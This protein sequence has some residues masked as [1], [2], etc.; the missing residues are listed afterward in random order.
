MDHFITH[1]G[2]VVIGILECFVVGWI[3]KA[4]KLREHINRASSKMVL[5]GF[6]DVCIK[7]IIPLVLLMLL[8][9]DLR[10]ELSAPYEG[11]SWV[12]ILIIGRDWLIIALI[13]SLFVAMRPWK[14][15][16]EEAP[17]A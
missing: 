10:V 11:Y 15:E 14:R 8:F 5:N 12:A 3:F 4:S 13:I 16:L 17:G 1:Y 6:W 9:N 2:L 7:V